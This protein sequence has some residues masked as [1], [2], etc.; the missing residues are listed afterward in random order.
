M[1]V[2]IIRRTA[3]IGVVDGR[4]TTSLVDIYRDADGDY[5]VETE[6]GPAGSVGVRVVTGT[7]NKA[8]IANRMFHLLV[9]NDIRQGFE[10]CDTHWDPKELAIEFD[11]ALPVRIR[12][13]AKRLLA[14]FLNAPEVIKT[15]DAIN[16]GFRKLRVSTN[17]ANLPCFIALVRNDL[18]VLKEPDSETPSPLDAWIA[19][20]T[21]RHRALLMHFG[22]VESPAPFNFAAA[23]G[24]SRAGHALVL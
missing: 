13:A 11:F 9:T 4:S 10:V 1:D 21:G 7:Y 16:Q 14:L 24:G 6:R 8:A 2:F 22:I 23:I 20:S 5:V 18:G 3:L 15:L 17:D 19:Q 12:G